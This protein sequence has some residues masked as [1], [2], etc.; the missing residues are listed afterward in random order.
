MKHPDYKDMTDEDIEIMKIEL[1]HE[2]ERQEEMQKERARRIEECD[3]Q[4]LLPRIEELENWKAGAEKVMQQQ[5]H[6]ME[7]II[8]VLEN[9]KLRS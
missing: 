2:F 5:N 9:M 6:N 1:A 8:A 7:R 4:R 3:P